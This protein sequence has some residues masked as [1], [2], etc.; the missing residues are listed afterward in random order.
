MET[1]LGVILRSSRG[2]RSLRSVAAELGCSKGTVSRWENGQRQPSKADLARLARLYGVEELTGVTQDPERLGTLEVAIE[3]AC[4][5]E[6][7]RAAWIRAAAPD[8]EVYLQRQIRDLLDR[9]IELEA[10][11]K[12]GIPGEWPG[13]TTVMS[14]AA[15]LGVWFE[16]LL[17]AGGST[18]RGVDV[19][20]PLEPD[21]LK[22]AGATGADIARL[23]RPNV[24]EG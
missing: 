2:S 11:K 17:R 10:W 1:D 19:G 14:G 16:E 20:V 23:R 12:S 21:E 8:P 15:L 4:A 13:K 24:Y 3:A 22:A 5:A 7:S 9:A 6:P 18:L